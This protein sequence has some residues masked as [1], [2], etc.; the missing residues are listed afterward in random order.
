MSH[1]LIEFLCEEDEW[2][3]ASKQAANCLFSERARAGSCVISVAGDPWPHDRPITI[4]LF[5]IFFFQFWRSEFSEQ[6]FP[7]CPHFG[8]CHETLASHE[9]TIGKLSKP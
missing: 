6:K 1:R 4:R 2:V 3:I 7:V 9:V 5:H 8:A